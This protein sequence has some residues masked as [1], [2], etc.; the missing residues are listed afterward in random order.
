MVVGGSRDE[1]AAGLGQRLEARGNIHGFLNLRK[2]IPSS[3]QDL[4]DGVAALKL[5]L[6]GPR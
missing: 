1:D 6:D 5:L 3:Q 2:A 4:L